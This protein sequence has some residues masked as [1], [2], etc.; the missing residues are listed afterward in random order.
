MPGGKFARLEWWE[1]HGDEILTP[2]R[3][4]RVIRM[5]DPRDPWPGT[6]TQLRTVI[7]R[8]AE[9]RRVRVET[10]LQK[11]GTELR[12]LCSYPPV[13]EVEME[14][15]FGAPVIQSLRP[16]AEPVQA[17]PEPEPEP[18][19]PGSENYDVEADYAHR[20]TCGL[21]TAAGTHPPSCKVWWSDPQGQEPGY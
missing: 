7:Y 16:Q 12:V 3:Y 15:V 21:G 8:Q 20:C 9:L 19:A 6:A 5:T 17:E 11:L 2:D 1:R 10:R 4:A 14:K 18:M 13:F